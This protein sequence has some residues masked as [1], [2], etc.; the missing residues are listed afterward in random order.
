[1]PASQ[2]FSKRWLREKGTVTLPDLRPNTTG[3]SQSL[4]R[5]SR[6]GGYVIP[7]G[8]VTEDQLKA[9]R[10]TASSD[11]RLKSLQRDPEFRLACE[12]VGVRPEEL[13]AP[14]TSKSGPEYESELVR[15]AKKVALVTAEQDAMA[16]AREEKA[17]RAEANLKRHIEL[18][19]EQMVRLAPRQH[20]P[21]P[22]F[23]SRSCCV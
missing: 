16:K 1:M 23:T 15:V 12:R 19:N 11:I 14:S 7:G 5:T 22:V 4:E 8:T 18:F 10:S 20:P 3:G 17:A 13:V 21:P 2:A 6:Y 9:A